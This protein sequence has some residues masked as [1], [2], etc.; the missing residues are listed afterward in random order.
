MASLDSQNIGTPHETGP[1]ADQ[2]RM[3]VVTLGDEACVM[4]DTGV[5]AYA[6][7]Q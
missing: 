4:Y 1:F 6:K 7:P 3:E 5:A 2:G